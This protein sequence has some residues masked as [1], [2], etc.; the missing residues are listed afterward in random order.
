MDP[1]N[2]LKVPMAPIYTKNEEGAR[3]K[4]AIFWSK[5]SKKVPKNAFFGLFF[6]QKL[7]AA[8]KFWPKQGLFNDLGEL[9]KSVWS[10]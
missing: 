2:F 1:K 8:Q 3:R 7:P 9:E 10:T 5:F 4:N 6:F